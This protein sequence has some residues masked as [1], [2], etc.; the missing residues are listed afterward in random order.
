MLRHYDEIGILHPET[1]DGLNGYRYYRKSQLPLAAK[2][3]SSKSLGFE[4][5]VIKEILGKYEDVREMKR[6]LLAKRKE[7]EEEA[8]ETQRKRMLLD[9][10][11]KWMR[12]DGRPTLLV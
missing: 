9:S 7:L 6:S 2:I 4:L 1:V 10:T 12:K 8:L 11:L 3:Q 5:S